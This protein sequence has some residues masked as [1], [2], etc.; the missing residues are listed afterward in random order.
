MNKDDTREQEMQ[1]TT[2]SGKPPRYRIATAKAAHNI[3]TK[4]KDEDERG[5]AKRR[6]TL[7]GM[8]DGN[9]PY[10]Q[11]ELDE[12]GLGY[13]VNVNFLGMRSQLDSR[14]AMS[15]ELLFEVPTLVEIHPRGVKADDPDVHHW[16]QIIAEEFSEMLLDWASFSTMTDLVVRECDAFGLGTCFF[17]NQWDWRPKPVRRSAILFDPKAPVDVDK[18]DILFIRDELSLCDIYQN[19]ADAELVEDDDTRDPSG[20]NIKECR[21]LLVRQFI[22]GE[23]ADDATFGYQTSQWEAVQHMAR[24]ND[25]GFDEKQFQ[26]LKVV[27]VLVKEVE[28][29]QKVSQYIIAESA[30]V[31]SFLYEKH[32]KY[33]LMSHAVWWLPYNYGNGFM[34]SVRGIAS[35]LAQHDDLSNRFLCEIFNAGFLSSKLLL[36]PGAEA[37]MSKLQFMMHGSLAII[38][39][40]TTAVQA[41]FQPQIG[42][43]I[44]LRDVS[45]KVMMNDLG[46][47]RLHPE[48]LDREQQKTARQVMEEAAT[49]ARYER[50]VVVHR[51][52]RMDH[53]YREIF[54]RAT[55][56]DYITGDGAYPGK[57]VVK[58]MLERCEERG[59]DKKFFFEG[60]RKMKLSATR[61]LGLGSASV[62]MD[63]TNQLMGASEGFDEIGKRNVMRDWV[64]AR[65]S[66]RNVDRYVAR[67]DRDQIPSNEMSIATLEWNDVSQGQPVQVGTDQMH[68]PHILV[69]MQKM[70]ELMAA[71]EQGQVQD[72]QQ[73]LVALQGGSQHIQEHGQ[74]IAQDPRHKQFIKQVEEFLKVVAQ[75]MQQL[76]RAVEQMMREQQKQAEAQ[77]QQLAEADQVIKDRELEAKIY[78]INKKA[79]LEA[80]KQQSLNDM[81]AQKTAEQMSISRERAAGDMQLKAQ[82]QAAE[83]EMDRAKTA[84]DVETKRAKARA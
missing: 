37:D 56:K 4:L 1:N 60:L 49:E 43:L 8:I 30:P 77:Q 9:A 78:E 63:L 46:I 2:P 15:H 67:V 68:K 70:A 82:R 21:A 72:P 57:D 71:V 66:Y 27:Y 5:P 36:Q 20:W 74:Q 28:G 83:I 73:A 33:D 81:R 10:N 50:I 17:D 59:V 26:K 34:R 51:Y 23:K 39:P 13:Q 41:T 11:K 19:I 6:A 22:G 80:M 18:H 69:F 76:Q 55:D 84:A 42:P 7:Q 61:A 64:A 40:G 53:L 52:N 25:A 62:K 54:R 65:T 79:E 58:E 12:A 32:G 24:N 75:M 38:P 16:C 14:A 44:N 48:G 35:L 45:Q 29:D 47:S 31:E 3:F